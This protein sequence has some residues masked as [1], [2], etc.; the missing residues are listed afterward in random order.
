[1][2]L[3]HLI[4]KLRGSLYFFV[5]IVVLLNVAY[6]F[7]FGHLSHSGDLLLWMAFAVDCALKL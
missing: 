3:A 1:M 7:L 2:P 4:T 5:F 6:S